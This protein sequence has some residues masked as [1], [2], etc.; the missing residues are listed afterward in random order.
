MKNHFLISTFF[1]L[2]LL[3]ICAPQGSALAA[4]CVDEGCHGDK[5]DFKFLHGPVALEEE[6]GGGCL[7]CHKP[8]KVKCGTG[9]KGAFVLISKD[10]YICTYC[11]EKSESPDHVGREKTCVKCHSS[12]GSNR[13][14]NLLK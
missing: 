13:G 14:P 2:L 1:L 8:T 7:A 6:P 12:H 5:I 4:S 11:H 10:D 9:K 3:L